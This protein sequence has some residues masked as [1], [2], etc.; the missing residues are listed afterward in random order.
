MSTRKIKTLAD[1]FK[2]STTRKRK[3][4][5]IQEEDANTTLSDEIFLQTLADNTRKRNSMIN[6]TMRKTIIRKPL[7]WNANSKIGDYVINSDRTVKRVE[8]DAES[9]ETIILC[10]LSNIR[11]TNDDNAIIQVEETKKIIT[12]PSET[13]KNDSPYS[14]GYDT[15]ETRWT[16]RPRPLRISPSSLLTPSTIRSYRT[17]TIGKTPS[18]GST[19][20]TISSHS[21]KSKK[22]KPKT[23]SIATSKQKK[24][25]NNNYKKKKLKVK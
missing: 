24:N 18:V 13:P 16:I 12:Y 10:E 17:E 9:V 1:A 15:D 2:P 6:S 8:N 7:N 20:S 21:R 5:P 19:S 22:S 23:K 11:P 4:T 25:Y 3:R 14:S